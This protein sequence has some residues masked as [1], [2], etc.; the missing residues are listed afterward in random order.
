[1]P[2]FTTRDECKIFYR[3]YSVD[4]SNSVVIFLNGTTQ[5]TM[6]WGNHVPAFAKHYGLLCYDARCQGQ[7]DAGGAPISLQLHVSDLYQ[8]MAHLAIDR[9][10]LVGIS[11]G[12][13][14][15]LEFSIE[16]KQMVEKL[17]LCS[18]SAR[19]SDRCRTIVRSWLEIL[20]L[21]DLGAMA[22]A[23]VPIVFG[24]RFLK[25][26]QKTLDKIINAVVFRNRKK[27]LLA[28]LDAVL[29]YPPTD[30]I[31]ADFNIPTLIVSGSEDLLV[32]SGDVRQLADLCKARHT[33]L[34][35]IGHSIP[36]EAPELFEKLVLEFLNSEL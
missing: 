13:R 20:N 15:A 17:V 26:H 3:T 23:A 32:D 30:S 6:Y 14:L 29:R 5:T 19:T 33:K 1:M 10:H 28:Q 9:A 16:F 18:V 22:W 25:H 27:A 24:P 35:G 8:L 36:A 12:A 34:A 21:S 2:Y 4:T 31:P 7:S 11:H